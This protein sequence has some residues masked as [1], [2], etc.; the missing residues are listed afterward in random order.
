MIIRSS[1]GSAPLACSRS[2]SANSAYVASPVFTMPCDRSPASCQPPFITMRR[3]PVQV[4]DIVRAGHREAAALAE[5]EVEHFQDRAAPRIFVDAE[6]PT[7][8]VTC[9]D[10]VSAGLAYGGKVELL[11]AAQTSLEGLHR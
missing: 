2:A 6:R 1:S 7:D 3:E 9:A 5:E 4:I 8:A 11:E 10:H